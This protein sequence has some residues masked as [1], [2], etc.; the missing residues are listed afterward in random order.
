MSAAAAR[1]PDY[2][3]LMV[4]YH[5]VRE[6]LYRALIRDAQLP[7]NARILDAG[8]GDCFYSQLLAEE[9]GPQAQI[10]AVD[11]DPA[12]LG[13][14]TRLRPN[15]HRCLSN[16]DRPGFEPASFDAIWLCRT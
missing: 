6:P 2:W 1:L 11:V 12:V 4:A 14:A 16:L 13:C 7:P 10:V 15:I 9:L 5:A 8:C 3:P